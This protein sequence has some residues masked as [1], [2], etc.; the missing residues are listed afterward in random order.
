MVKQKPKLSFSFSFLFVNIL[1]STQQ[2]TMQTHV[3][4]KDKND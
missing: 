2:Q 3:L 1:F 4:S